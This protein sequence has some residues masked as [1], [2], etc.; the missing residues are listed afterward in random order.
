[1][2]SINRL[3][4][5]PLRTLANAAVVVLDGPRH[6]PSRCHRFQ[7]RG[8]VVL[9]ASA[10]SVPFPARHLRFVTVSHGHSRSSDLR[11]PYN[12]CAAARMVRMGS[13]LVPAGVLVSRKQRPQLKPGYQRGKGYSEGFL[14]MSSSRDEPRLLL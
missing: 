6:H 13:A 4:P 5:R 7:A 10:I 8:S 12:R 3:L 14:C 1:M 2:R 9:N 11:P